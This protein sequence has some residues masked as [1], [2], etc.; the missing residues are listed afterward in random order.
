VGKRPLGFPDIVG[1]LAKNARPVAVGLL[2]VFGAAAGISV[3][4]RHTGSDTGLSLHLLPDPAT[5]AGVPLVCVSTLHVNLQSGGESL[6]D[7][8]Y[9]FQVPGG[10]VDLGGLPHSG[11]G[12]FRVAGLNTAVATVFAGSSGNVAFTDHDQF[13]DVYVDCANPAPCSIA[14]PPLT[15]FTSGTNAGLLLGEPDATT[16]DPQTNGVAADQDFEE[17]DG[18]FVLGS[19]LWI[20]D[21]ANGRTV[22]YLNKNALT[23]FVNDT[24]TLAVGHGDTQGQGNNGGQG[25]EN[26]PRGVW[27][28]PDRLL[29]GD[30]SNHRVQEY[31]PVP[32][33]SNQSSD[34]SIGQNGNG[35][36]NDPGSASATNLKSPV[37]SIVVGTNLWVADSG[38]NRVLRYDVATLGAN[39]PAANLV[40]G[41]TT[42]TSNGAGTSQSALSAPAHLAS[43]GQLLWVADTG[44]NRVLGFQ[45]STI[46]TGAPAAIVL[47]QADFTSG[48]ANRGGTPAAD[49]LAGPRGIAIESG[50]LVVAD[51]LNHRLLIW[52]PVPDTNGAPAS[53]VL[54]QADFTSNAPNY[55]GSNNGCPGLDSCNNPNIGKR[56]TLHTM[57][58]PGAVWLDGDDLW[59]SDTCNNR[60]LR[61][62]A[63]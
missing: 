4:C 55:D 39:G 33:S 45:L 21:R 61:F 23:G 52:Q 54:G 28:L 8:D 42:F 6:I 32:A 16:C 2:L 51:S 41:Q 18:L 20:A 43:D 56:P 36:T 48:A 24:L 7:K 19:N 37:G 13:V 29:V 47:G 31:L 30:T 49:T 58:R 57:A 53:A 59:V 22:E 3:G 25:G 9:P 14:T 27:V 62:T 46:A 26:K 35:N 34:F 11:N 38:F 1:I 44:N 63:H 60:V 40:L 10:H 5:C 50:R 17:P 15:V 12:V